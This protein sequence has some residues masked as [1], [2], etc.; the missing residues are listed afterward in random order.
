MP[1]VL[2]DDVFAGDPAMYPQPPQ[3]SITNGYRSDNNQC[4]GENENSFH[5]RQDAINT[6]NSYGAISKQPKGIEGSPNAI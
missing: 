5:S 6:S 1:D 2:K 3:N 4:F